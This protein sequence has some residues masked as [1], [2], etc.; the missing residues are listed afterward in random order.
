MVTKLRCDA[1]EVRVI[2]TEVDEQGRPIAELP[3]APAKLF[4]AAVP[5]IWAEVDKSIAAFEQQRRAQV[6][7]PAGRRKSG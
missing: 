1:I 3:S 5:D 7:P 6:A 2:V 4:R